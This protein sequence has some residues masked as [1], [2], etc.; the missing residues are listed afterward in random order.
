MLLHH[1]VLPFYMMQDKEFDFYLIQ[2]QIISRHVLTSPF[3]FKD[4]TLSSH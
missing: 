2:I 4:D 3:G 1:H